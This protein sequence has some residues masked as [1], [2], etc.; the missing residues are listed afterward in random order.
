MTATKSNVI[1]VV[2]GPGAGMCLLI[3]YFVELTY[4]INEK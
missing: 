3:Y 1:F 2:G 4:L